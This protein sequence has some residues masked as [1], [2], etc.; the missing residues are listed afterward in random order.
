MMN[1][2]KT[3]LENSGE[4]FEHLR[5]RDTTPIQPVAP[6]ITMNGEIITTEGNI[7]TISGEAKCGKT[8][9]ASILIS[10]ALSEKGIVN[11]MEELYVLPNT[12]GKAILHFDTEQARHT[13]KKN[14]LAILSRSGLAACPEYFCSYNLK[15]LDPEEFTKITRE[16]CEYSHNLFNGI[17]LI[18]VDS[19][20]DYLADFNDTIESGFVI[21]FFEKLAINYSVPIIIVIHT[22]PGKIQKEIGHLGSYFQRRSES[23]LTIKTDN[24]FSYVIPKYLRMADK[25]DILPIKF[26]YD[27][28][29][30]YHTGCKINN[31]I[32]FDDDTDRVAAISK[33]CLGIF[34]D[35]LSLLLDDAIQAIIKKTHKATGTAKGMFKEM[36][37]HDMIT[38]GSNKKWKVN[39]EYSYTGIKE[40]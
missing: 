40:N 12:S 9:F 1:N 4:K 15:S 16:I 21:S 27:K 23:V 36:V 37:A 10:S 31:K 18:I 11:G 35:G 28:E 25:K 26:T 34:K 22:N 33:I 13:H 29:L 17:H 8:A 39:P 6:I 30:G 2:S 32:Q 14:H 19:V 20:A 38:Q 24:N 7:T 5:I 3:P